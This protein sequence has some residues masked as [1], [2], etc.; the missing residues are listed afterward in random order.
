MATS[1]KSANRSNLLILI[2]GLC[3]LAACAGEDGERPNILI[4][5]LDTT[6][7]DH[8]GFCGYDRETSPNIDRIA[9]DA[10][11]YTQ[12]YSTASTTLPAHASLFTG[13]LVTSH[14]ARSDTEGPLMLLDAI[15]GPQEWEVYRARGL[16]PDETTLASLLA[17]AGYKTGAIVAGPWLKRVFGL[18]RGFEFYDD[19][20]ISDVN[21][22]LAERVTASALSWLE[23]Q[24]A[25]R[26]CLFLNYFDAHAPYM[27][28]EA[29][30]QRLFS[31]ND[32]GR[33]GSKNEQLIVRYDAEIL[34]MDHH[35]GELIQTLKEWDLYDK[36]WIIVT[37]DHGELLGEHQL[38][39]HGKYLYEEEIRVPL[40]S[41]RPHGEGAGQRI[42]GR[43]QL[44]DV[45]P[46]ICSGLNLPLP[47]G[48]QGVVPADRTLPIVAE[49]YPNEFISAHGYWRTLLASD[50]KFLWNSKEKHLLFN[51]KEDPAEST[52]LSALK[53][54]LAAK[55][56][57]LLDTYLE[58]L[59]KPGEAGP[60]V[61][62]DEE[63][64]KALKGLGYVK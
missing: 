10:V 4:I 37:A 5:T 64:A 61:Q 2:L 15:E 26:F 17:E 43:L 49:T 31:E 28:P 35:I 41:K 58:S 23:K 57:R 46:M 9:A 29:F 27:P 6:R 50:F 24:R 21:G 62:V 14:G 18:D 40:I 33:P 13:K 42:D 11:V 45:L 63:T 30:V 16:T 7:L 44:T 54:E 19:A 25:D 47:P 32:I 34:Y 3:L 56:A 22:R 1:R 55:M 60:P 51:L 52:D 59:P 12:V 8:L 39:G 48:I 20:E 38:I 36:T 53:P